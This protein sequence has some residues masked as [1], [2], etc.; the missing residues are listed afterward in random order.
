MRIEKNRLLRSIVAATLAI[1]PFTSFC[2][3]SWKGITSTTWSTASNWTAGVPTATT[4]VIIGD[5]S[6]TGPFQPNVSATATCKTLTLGAGTGTP[7]LTLT[8]GLTVSGNLTI[9]TGATLTQKGVTLKVTGNWSN[10]GTYTTTSTSSSVTFAGV[11]ETI[12][13]S[14]TTAFR[15]LTINAGSTTTLNGNISVSGA[16]TVT[17]TFIPAENATPYLVSGAGTLSVGAAGILKVNA[18]TFSANYGLSGTITLTAGCTVEYS[19]TLVNQT[20]KE[21]LT[22]S[23]LKISGSGIKTPAGNLIALNSTSSTRG[24]ITVSSGTLDLSTFTANRGTTVTGGTLTVANGATLKIG[25]ANPFPANYNTR[26]LSLTST[27]EYGGTGQTVSAQTYGNL[28]FSSSAGAAVKTMPASNFTVAGNLS[29]TI[30]AGTSVTFTAAS[31]ITVSGNVS[32]GASTTFDGSTFTHGVAG[33]WVNNGVFTGSTSTITMS[34]A[35]TA[36]S[37]TGTHNFNNLTITASNITAAATSNITIAGNLSSSG[38]GSFTHTS[39]GTTTMTGTT[40]TITGTG[41]TFDNLTISGTVSTANNLTITGN[42]SVGG[43]LT[44]SGGTITLSGSAKT[45]SGAGTIA[46]NALSVTGTVTTAVGFSIGVSLNVGGSLTASAGTA[47]FSGS[48]TLNGA[49][50]LFN[51]TLN[52]TSLQ[53]STSA[54]L[55]IAGTYTITSGSL[56]TTSTTPNTVNFN[57]SGAQTVTGSSYNNLILSNGNTKTAGGA[58]TVNGDFTIAASTTFN[59][60]SFTHTM[61]GNW[62]NSGSFT[63]ATSTITFSGTADAAISGATTFNVLTINKSSASNKVNLL[64]NVAV[65]TVNMTNGSMNTGS[66][67]ITIT[68]TRTGNGIIL[69]NI[70]RTHTYTLGT[71][72]AF[73]GPNNTIT[74]T[75]LNAVTS[76]TVNVTIG[77]ISD[78]PLGG[79]INRV[80]TITVTGSLGIS[81]A[82]LRLHYEDAELNG[83]NEST[84][85]QWH[86][87]TGSSSWATSGKTANS[88]T[89]NYVEQTL[90]LDI[91]GRW[92][93]SDNANVVTWNGSASNDWFTA[94][95]WTVTQG[96]PSRPPGINDIVQIGTAAF[97][98]APTINNSASAKSILFG[99]VQAATLTLAAGGSLTVQGNLSGTWAANAAHTINAGNQTI[100]VNGDMVLSDGASGHAIN[101]NIGTGTVALAGSLTETG[102]AN[103]TFTGAG[104]LTIGDDFNYTSGTFTAGTGT[105]TYNGTVDQTIAAVNYNNVVITKASGIASINNATTIGGN[106]SVTSGELDINAAT[107]VTGNVTISSGGILNGDGVTTSVGGNWNNTGSFVSSSGSVFL[108]GTAAQSIAATTFNNLTINKAS[109]TATLAGNLSINGTLSVSAGTMDISTFTCN[110]STQ[111]GTLSVSNGA[112]ILAG[113]AGNFPSGYDVYTLGNS[114]TVNYNGTVAQTIAGV[115]YGNLSFTNG[116]ASAKTLAA[117]AVI[118]GDLTISSGASLNASS[119]TINLGGNWT[120]SGTFTAGT[121]TVILNGA[122]KTITGNT[123]FNRLTVYGSYS[124]PGSDLT[125][126]GLV[127]IATGGSFNTGT[128]TGTVNGDLTNNGSLTSFG[129]T[130]FTGTSVQTIR[131]INAVVSNS[132]GVIN[133]NGNVAPVLNSTSSPTFATLNVNNTAGVTASVGWIVGVAF[134]ISAGA[135]FNGGAST[136]NIF[137]SFTNNGTVTSSGTLNFAPAATQ[138]ITLAGTSFSST[139]TVIFGGSGAMT[140]S[141]TPTSLNNVVIANTTGVTPAANWNIGAGF[142]VNSNAIFNAGSNTFTVGGDLESDGVLNGGT[143]SFTM[144]SATGQISGSAGTVFYDFIVTGSITVNIDFN[145]AHNFTN[146]NAFDASI[147][148]LIMTGTGPSSIGGT[149]SPYTLAQFA[150]QK[151]TA[152]TAT[153]AK[154][155]TGVTD[156]HIYSGTLDASTFSITQDVGGGALTIDDSSFLSIGGTN[157]LP[158]FTTY[159]LDTFSTVVYAGSIQAISTATPYGNLTISAA[160]AKTAAAAL[161][162]LTNFSLASGTFVPG[163]FTDT[164]EGNWSMTSG[165]FTNTGNTILLSGTGTQDISSTGTFNNLTLNKTAGLTTLSTDATVNGVL[166]FTSGKIR[167]GL[168]TMILPA[169]ASTSGASSSSGWVFGRLKKNVVTGSNV[170]RVFEIGDSTSYTPATLLFASVSVTGNLVAVTTTSDHPNLATSGIN[171]NKSVNRYWSFTNSATVFTTAAV[172]VNWVAADVDAGAVTSNFKVGNYNGSS[173]SLPSVASPLSTSIQATGLSSIGDIAV[174]ELTTSGTWTGAVSNDWFITGNWSSG[175]IPT[176]ASNVTIPSALSIYPTI[177]TGT[178]TTNNLTIQSGASVTISGAALQIA[179]TITNSGTV[180]AG[181][182]SIELNGTSTQAIPAGLFTGNALKNLTINNTAGAA[183]NGTLNISGVLT[184]LNGSL[185]TGGYLTLLSTAAQTA[186]IN[187]SGTGEV[188]GNVTMQR[189]LAAGFGYKYFSSPFQADTAGDFSSVINLGASFPDLYKFDESL[190]SNGWVNYTTSSGLLTP[191]AGYAVNFGSSSAPL[192][193]SLKGVVNN[194]TVSSPILYNHNLAYTQGFNLVGNPYPSPIDWN[195]ATG[196]TKTNI[197]NALYYFSAGTTD[198]YTGTYSSYINGVSSNGIASNIIP[199]MQGYFIHVSNGTYP[200]AGLLSVNNNARNTNLST[201]FLGIPRP[202]GPPPL[203]RL[204]AALAGETAASDP[205]V[206]YFKEGATGVFDKKLDALK[207]MNTD[208]EVPNLYALSS[209]AAQLSIKAISYVPDSIGILPL[210][211]RTKKAG[212]I[213][214][215]ATSMERIPDGLHIYLSDAV[216]GIKKDLQQDPGYRLYLEA[217]EY[218]QRFYL[219]FSQKDTLYQPANAAFNAYGADGRL[220]VYLELAPGEKG[221]LV[222]RNMLGQVIWRKRIASSG[223]YES[224]TEFSSGIYLIS[225]YSQKGLRSIKI[226]ID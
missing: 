126:N 5:A 69:G 184:A 168:N 72:Y 3:T 95:N 48:S 223:H 224:D 78:F 90:L 50:N 75:G 118:N 153:L 121:G 185:T 188:L 80:Y 155:V 10:A 205:V 144:S 64:S 180:A 29:S 103:I 177:S 12:G 129:V 122:S 23:T 154:N 128:G 52:G 217:G 200:V 47:T 16:F 132:Q 105:V 39:G 142:L 63:A 77:Q 111:G 192:T 93:L 169:G 45:I 13:G 181:T 201:V 198:P 9:N 100:T 218:E 165:A 94:A 55:G 92:T 1:L 176:S 65:A 59:A 68:T 66:N 33:N 109:G 123:T 70:Q 148:T 97:T 98:N 211:L 89:S 220:H 170:T 150:I 91:S 175:S 149:A 58:I 161:H 208:P 157:S 20:I 189:Y 32:I 166:N 19:A 135:T 27:V 136:H 26:S 54:V 141:G 209:D 101:L 46:F 133:F 82:T 60:S 163:S 36:I 178:A 134:N 99:S 162:I 106:L 120:N 41:F 71:A 151:S 7:T 108:N 226:F 83:N 194:H 28:T 44:C 199:A 214:F 42:L 30:G 221:D 186:L 24:N 96:S 195:A 206:V 190:A 22:Y 104:A 4:D 174:G 225:F 2:Q 167:T 124:V 107:G 116:G 145:V 85:Q 79:S 156:L 38:P 204:N 61:T 173:W 179:G 140:I 114:S 15:K 197:D 76:I 110:R 222:I 81:V 117:S 11:S 21:T 87:A 25:G 172:T 207:L 215:N 112:T 125:Y 143:S 131:F 51:V 49:A 160:G 102:G 31:N 127:V 86:A 119:F 219:I 202:D 17:G 138:T 67:T 147:G 57:G 56:N 196:W 73:E 37:G 84:I 130:T 216:T 8:K 62:T 139:G 187:G 191:L 34:G 171:N 203:L 137:G 74:I 146:N 193:I 210:G 113:G 213:T 164:L 40:K 18:A 212:W 14:S 43:T 152:A 183:L 88:T 158:A 115:T 53:L 159:A 6:F 35:A 182:G